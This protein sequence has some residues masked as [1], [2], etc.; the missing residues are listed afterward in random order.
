MAEVTSTVNT[1]IHLLHRGITLWL[2]AEQ[3]AQDFQ[4]LQQKHH[5]L[6]VTYEGE[7]QHSRLLQDDV[8]QLQVSCIYAIVM[9]HRPSSML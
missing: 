2:Q 7:Q 1:V 9:V 8:T 3:L 4:A 6:A 5:R